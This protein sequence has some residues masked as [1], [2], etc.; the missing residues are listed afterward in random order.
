MTKKFYVVCISLFISLFALILVLP[1][2]SAV[3][4]PDSGS[5]SQPVPLVKFKDWQ[6]GRSDEGTDKDNA[7]HLSFITSTQTE[8]HFSVSVG[9]VDGSQPPNTSPID[10]STVVWSLVDASHI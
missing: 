5:G 8:S 3:E 2:F 7:V 9:Y 4:D 1:C 6:V 10:P